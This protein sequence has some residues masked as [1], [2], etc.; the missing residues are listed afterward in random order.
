MNVLFVS[1]W[2]TEV[3]WLSGNK[4]KLRNEMFHSR[5]VTG[6]VTNLLKIMKSG[7][8]AVY[9]SPTVVC[10]CSK[11]TLNSQFD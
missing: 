5:L 1:E 9:H 3:H 7:V 8:R 2:P 10:V 4:Y 11:N 6:C